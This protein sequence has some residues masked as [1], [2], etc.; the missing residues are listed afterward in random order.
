MRRFPV[1]FLM[2]GT[3]GTHGTPDT[4]GTPGTPGMGT[5]DGFRGWETNAGRTRHT[6][7][8]RGTPGLEIQKS[9]KIENLKNQNVFCP[10]CRQSLD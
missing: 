3:P 10:K 2:T 5:G 8:V 4:P 7:F 6:K 1:R 9:L